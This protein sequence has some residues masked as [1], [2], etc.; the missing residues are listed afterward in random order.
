MDHTARM[1]ATC[2]SPLLRMI[3]QF[4]PFDYGD[5][6]NGEMQQI[7]FRLQQRKH[8]FPSLQKRCKWLPGHEALVLCNTYFRQLAKV[9]SWQPEH[10]ASLTPSIGKLIATT[11]PRAFQES[12]NPQEFDQV[13]VLL[14]S[15]FDH[16][17]GSDATTE[18][19]FTHHPLTP[20]AT[21]VRE[22]ARGTRGACLFQ[23][24]VV[25]YSS[26]KKLTPRETLALATDYLKRLTALQLRKELVGQ[27]QSK[28]GELVAECGVK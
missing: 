22:L 12:E 13:A 9:S 28:I 1:S 20:G 15:L 24:V 27:L 8:P 5:I 17:S 14:N 26:Q 7:L 10:I 6:A 2:D 18:R 21:L 3:E 11:G 4:G 19:A 16:F 25:C 23:Q